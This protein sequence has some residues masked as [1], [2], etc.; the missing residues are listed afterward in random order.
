MATTDEQQAIFAVL[1]QL[2]TDGVDWKRRNASTTMDVSKA[3]QQFT[4]LKEYEL[5]WMGSQ[6]RYKFQAE[7]VIHIAPP[8]ESAVAAL[9]CRWNFD[10]APSIC[11]FYFGIWSA[12]P[13]FPNLS[14][15]D[16]HTAFIGFR[17]ETPEVG[18]NHDYYHAQPCRSM[19]DTAVVCS[20]PISSRF[21]TFPLAAQSSLKLLLCLVTSVY[22]MIGL[23]KLQS[24]VYGDPSMR[25]N[26]LLRQSIEDIL[27]LKR[28]AGNG[29]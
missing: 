9:W 3:A 29:S 27:E 17:Y 20:L 18:D 25:R 15:G 11:G 1:R 4:A 24:K 22:G 16:K 14:V 19:G 6:S 2:L 8:S 7:K 10:E 5:D 28:H 13:A 26:T 23:K 21:P 12:Q